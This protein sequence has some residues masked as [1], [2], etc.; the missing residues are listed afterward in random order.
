MG[1]FLLVCLILLGLIVLVTIGIPAMAAHSYG[2]AAPG[3]SAIQLVQYS[4]KLLWDDGLLSR[5]RD[6][7]GPAQDFQV[8]Q[9]ESILSVCERLASAGI[10]SEAS[11]LRD[12]L[13][14]SGLDTSIQAGTYKVSPAMS[15]VDIAH[16][17]Q[18][19]TP[20]ETTF[21][22]LPGWRIEEIAASLPTSGLDITPEEFL[23]AAK[24]PPG[25]YDFLVGASTAEGFLYPDAYVLPRAA[26]A[27][28]VLEAMVRNFALHLDAR[29]T[30][31]FARQGLT[32]YQAVTLGSIIEREAIR[33]EEAPL[34]ASVYLNRIKIGMR[35]EADPTVQYALGFDAT[36]QTW[37]TNPLSLDDLRVASPFNTYQNDGL[38]PG[39]ID[40][41]GLTSLQAVAA[42]AN[43]PYYY[44]SA[45]CDNSGYHTFAQTFAEH[46]QNLCP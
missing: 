38:P 23:S 37:W 41:P 44:F 30:E 32:V 36:Q 25:G 26:T 6:P 17:M 40:N 7:G 1:R 16:R 10:I 18:D 19:A 21:V 33:A 15:V 39:P 27:S 29:L 11:L 28:D 31:G 9:G 14:Y 35:L 42:P 8:A 2:P 4:A 20:T 13:V 3:L 12:Y 5:P 22:V 45:R 46:M 34:I 43:T 24:A